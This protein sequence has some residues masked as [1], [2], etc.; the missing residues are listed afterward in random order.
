MKKGMGI[1]TP[2]WGSG[3]EYGSQANIEDQKDN[4]RTRDVGGLRKDATC[5]K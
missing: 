5:Y 1:R 4:N 3:L 2:D